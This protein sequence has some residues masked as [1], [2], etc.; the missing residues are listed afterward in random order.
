MNLEMLDQATA[1]LQSQLAKSSSNRRNVPIPKMLELF[2]LG[3]IKS[4][5]ILDILVFLE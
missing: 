2:I 1:Q 3:N 5:K 4:S